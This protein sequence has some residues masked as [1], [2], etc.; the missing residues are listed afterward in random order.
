MKK[1]FPIYDIC[2]LSDYRQDDVLIN[3]F[4]HYLYT[5]R[6]LHFPH[7]HNFYHLV[8]FTKGG[9]SHTIDFKTF[10]VEPYQIYFM[11]PGQVH[12]WDFEGEVDGYLVHFSAEFFPSFLLAGDYLH[13]FPFFNGDID[14]AVI[15]LTP[16]IRPKV[17]TLFEELIGE[18]EAPG[19]MNTDMIR[20]LLL[21][22]F[23]LLSRME[24]NHNAKKMSV[25]N[26]TLIK[27]FRRL[28]EKNYTK[29]R[30]PK[31]Y[32][33]LLY[34]TPNHLNAVSNDVLGMPAGEA[35]RNRV[36]LEAK[37]LLINRD[38][39]ISEIAYQLNFN[40][41]SYF[42]KFFKNY[43]DLTPEEFRKNTLN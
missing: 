1:E 4:G 24:K 10:D 36:L 18:T 13:H 14:D 16:E 20:L 29:L 2:K 42:T 21:Q 26:Y 17:I 28:I 35:I 37:R 39:S 11:T 19:R 30:L 9:G 6:D 15:N 5:H 25:Y 8:L 3:R 27:N 34:I 12:S 41:N 31:E 38:M 32:A 23:I 43:T 22:I 33:E 40:D 7:K